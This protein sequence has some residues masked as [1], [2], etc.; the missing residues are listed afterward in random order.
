MRLRF[1]YEM[2]SYHSD[3]T[4]MEKQSIQ[5]IPYQVQDFYHKLIV[6]VI[7]SLTAKLGCGTPTHDGVANNRVFD[8]GLLDVGLVVGGGL[9]GDLAGG[10]GV[11]VGVGDLKGYVG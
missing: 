5:M 8:V 10:G 6:C 1:I 4:S 7:Y 3:S 9:A 11:G 2:I